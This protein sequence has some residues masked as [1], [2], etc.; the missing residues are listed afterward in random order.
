MFDAETTTLLREGDRTHDVG[1]ARE[2]LD[3]HHGG[4][5]GEA[6][7]RFA[8]SNSVVGGREGQGYGTK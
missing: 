8:G 3:A 1:R 2:Y 5:G 6:P 7:G 4:V